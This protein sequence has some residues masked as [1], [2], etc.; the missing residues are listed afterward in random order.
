MTGLSISEQS[1][2]EQTRI[3][4]L[5]FLLSIFICAAMSGYSGF[6]CT[7]AADNKEKIVLEDKVN[8][9]T[10]T[11]ASM[12]RLPS[13]GAAKARAIIEYRRSGNLF[14]SAEDL[15]NIKGIGPKTVET[16]RPYLRFE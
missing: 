2:R 7:G 6:L 11:A 13:F 8:P 15:D 5:A 10:D 4:S 16:V 3:Q 1:E 14:R 9:N 12:I